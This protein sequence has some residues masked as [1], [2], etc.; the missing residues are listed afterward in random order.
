MQ[1]T[2]EREQWER[3]L[4]GPGQKVG[5]KAEHFAGGVEETCGQFGPR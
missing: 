5:L 4:S 1:S 2:Y 3:V